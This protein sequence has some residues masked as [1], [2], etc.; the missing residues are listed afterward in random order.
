MLTFRTSTILI[1]IV[2]VALVVADIWFD[3]PLIVYIFIILA[4]GLM[5]GFGS[6]FVQSNFFV[7]AICSARTNEKVLALSF[8]DGPQQNFTPEIL[9]ILKQEN[10]PGAFFCIGKNI[11]QEPDILRHVIE[12][13][14]IVGN[15]SYTHSPTFDLKLPKEMLK[16]IQMADQSM[17]SILGLKPKLFRPPY[18][19][20]TPGMNTVMKTGGYTAIGW[21]I[22]SYDTMTNNDNKL[23]KRLVRLLKPGAVV[24][25][26]DT[27]QVT[28][29]VLPQFIKAARNA[30]YRF[31]RLD[32]LLN[33]QPYA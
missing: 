3:V 1:V 19:V 33:V 21:N 31:V 28:V 16:D 2:L 13:G 25:L 27:Q 18:G 17:I 7:P 10:V 26:H 14:H 22:R 8:D 23:L 24:L 29:R 30:G 15:H 5:I 12:D 4:Y 9:K 32:T 11:D 20:T 6:Y